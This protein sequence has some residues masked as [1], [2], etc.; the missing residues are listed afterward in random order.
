MP[1]AAV[2]PGRRIK[3]CKECKGRR[4]EVYDARLD[5]YVVSLPDQYRDENGKVRP[6]NYCSDC[7]RAAG[8]RVKSDRMKRLQQWLDEEK[9]NVRERVREDPAVGED[10]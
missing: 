9:S 5:R 8:Q 1:E 4:L 10:R 3:R 2:L 6:W 7:R